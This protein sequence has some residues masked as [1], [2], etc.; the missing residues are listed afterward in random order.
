MHLQHSLHTVAVALLPL[1]LL[2][3]STT[4]AEHTSVNRPPIKVKAEQFQGPPITLPTES[5]A[6]AKADRLSLT[7]P[8]T[9]ISP[10]TVT[11]GADYLGIGG[12]PV[13]V[14]SG[15]EFLSFAT[16]P[17]ADELSKPH[18]TH[19]KSHYTTSQST[20]PTVKANY[21]GVG[22]GGEPVTVP[23]GT[24]F[25]SFATAQADVVSKPPLTFTTIPT[26]PGQG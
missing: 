9:S 12:E 25:L 24:E 1:A 3:T 22:V 21:L 26:V 17:Q 10:P 13:T 8:H 18:R 20:Y 6:T 23:S 4:S 19:R 5:H 7:K 14:P 2:L 11:V 15:T 16:A